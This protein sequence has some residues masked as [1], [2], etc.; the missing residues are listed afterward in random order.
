MKFSDGD[1]DAEKKWFTIDIREVGVKPIKVNE[2]E[3]IHVKC[4]VGDDE[5]RRCFY[6]YSGQ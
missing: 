2:G 5:M 4:K 1:K 6:G 3:V